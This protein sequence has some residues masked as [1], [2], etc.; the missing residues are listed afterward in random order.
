MPILNMQKLNLEANVFV[1]NIDPI[2]NQKELENFFKDAGDVVIIDLR[3]NDRGESLGYG[4]VQFRTKEQANYCVESMNGTKL[5][6][7]YLQIEIFKK[8]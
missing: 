2:L 5:G 1:R 3:T 7:K 4:C 6:E 8:P